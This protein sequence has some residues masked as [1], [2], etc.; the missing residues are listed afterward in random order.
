[1]SVQNQP[2]KADNSP[3]KKNYFKY[4]F[5]KKLLIS[6]GDFGGTFSWGFLGSFSSI[7]YTDVFGLGP[8]M[9]SAISLIS[10][11]WDGIN[12]PMIGILADRTRSRW[13]RY[14]PWILFGT[15]PVV[16]MLTLCFWA[17]PNWNNSAKFIYALLT[18]CGFV[19]AYTCVN[20]PYVAMQAT[21]TQDPTERGSIAG[22]RLMT[23]MI[24]IT[25][26][27]YAANKMI[28]GFGNGDPVR[29]YVLT[30]LTMALIGAPFLLLCFGFSKERIQPQT[31][32]KMKIREGL[33]VIK[34][35]KPLGFALTGQFLFGFLSYGR[36]S[37]Y[38]YY[39]TYCL[40][41]AVALFAVYAII[42]RLCNA[43]G[44][45]TSMFWVRKFKNKG[46][47][48]FLGY[49]LFGIILIL[50]GFTTPTMMPFAFWTCTAVGNYFCGIA[51]AQNYGIVPDCV[52][53][54]EW[55]TG[56]RA[57]G[58]ISSF[59]SFFSKVG[60]AIGT[61]GSAA[62]LGALGYVA[63]QQQSQTVLTGINTFMFWGTGAICLITGLIFLGYKLS[64]ERFDQIVSEIQERRRTNV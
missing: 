18:Y 3:K 33:K 22:I 34:G 16:V 24:S 45:A 29:G 2:E 20:M 42:A 8:W 61:F 31:K 6:G 38:M 55:Q 36:T 46:R 59:V 40:K 25:I 26:V 41:D 23:G 39:F 52:E 51:Y 14:R 58:F 4:P 28:A 57:E 10:R 49:T 35:N 44:S 64:N 43:A 13:G 37:V 7:F 54:G 56:I 48:I 60:M 11:I 27:S 32:E 47:V 21:L 63:N 12:D 5:W 9:V 50:Q 30:A 17:H 62:M 1:M 19:F 15:L 53:Y